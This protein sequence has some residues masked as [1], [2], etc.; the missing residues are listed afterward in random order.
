MKIEYEKKNRRFNFSGTEFSSDKTHWR[1]KCDNRL[2]YRRAQLSVGILHWHESLEVCKMIRGEAVFT[3]EDQEYKFK[4]GDIVIIPGKSLHML[5]C[6]G[7]YLA[8]VFL[9][10]P[11]KLLSII[12]EFSVFPSYI[13]AEQIEKVEGLKEE[14]D[15]LF[16]RINKEFEEQKPYFSSIAFAYALNVVCLLSRNFNPQKNKRVKNSEII[17]PVLNEIRNDATN[18]EYSLAFFAKKLGYTT[19]YFSYIFK[20]YA[21]IGFK[22]FLDRQRIDQAKRIMILK[23]VSISQLASI[24]GYNNVRTFNN[25]FRELEKMSPSQF[26][27]TVSRRQKSTEEII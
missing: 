21:G 14:I 9:I 3:I 20:E 1:E 25:R 8:D 7:D 18:P 27:K 23:D 24:C 10:P 13:S 22:V 5:E 2:L 26:Q 16:E 19:E 17:E 6:E 11:H 12:T 15:Y 4:A